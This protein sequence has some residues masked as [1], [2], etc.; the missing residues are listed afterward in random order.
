MKTKFEGV[1]LIGGLSLCWLSL[2]LHL[3]NYLHDIRLC[4]EALLCRD[5]KCCN[6]EHVRAINAYTNDITAACISAAELTIPQVSSRQQSRRIPGW[7]EYVLPFR[8]KSLFWHRM[9]L[10]CGRPRSG[11]VADCMRRSRLA[12]H[13]AIRKVRKDEEFY[14]SERIAASML[15]NNTRD[16]WAE[17]KRIR[18][19]SAG[20]S[21]TDDGVSDNQSISKIFVDKYRELYTCVCHS[22]DDIRHIQDE[23]NDKIFQ[24]ARSDNLFFSD[25]DIRAAVRRLKPH[26]NDVCAGLASDHFINAG[27][28]CFAHISMLFNAMVHG[29]L[30]DVFLYSTI[31]PIPKTRNVNLSD[32]S[33]YSGIALSSLYGKLFGNV[34]LM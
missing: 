17:I 28:D 23:I 15:S 10:D 1:H 12:Y 26:K 7:S 16:F 33:N 8:E 27:D 6:A 14:K 24:E 4:H 9:W 2:G 31:V 20:V 29:T 32:S 25:L 19:N 5:V 3:S 18:S 13:Y 21:S 30:P 22:V 11:A 34:V